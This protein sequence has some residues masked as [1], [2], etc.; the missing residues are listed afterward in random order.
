M[1]PRRAILAACAVEALSSDNAS[2]GARY[3][4][5]AAPIQ[6]ASF[7]TAGHAPQGGAAGAAGRAGLAQFDLIA[8][9]HLALCCD[10]DGRSGTGLGREHAD[11]PENLARLIGAR[12]G[13]EHRQEVA[14]RDLVVAAEIDLDEVAFYDA[15]VPA[16]RVDYVARR[17]AAGRIA[18]CRKLRHAGDGDR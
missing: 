1:D 18:P 11:L 10:D 15:E 17:A 4:T 16:A 5:R 7:V 2:P 3:V 12:A 13:T 14:G 9:H 8:H 6:A